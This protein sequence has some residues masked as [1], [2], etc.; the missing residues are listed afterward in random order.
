MKAQEMRE[1]F[2]KYLIERGHKEFPSASLLPD[3]DPSV[4]FTTAGMHPLVPY[5]LGERHPQGKRL[6][7]AQKCLRTDDI[8]EVGDEFHHTYFEMLGNWSLGD[9]FKNESI[10]MSF[11]FLT[12]VLSIPICKLAVTVFGG[13]EEIP[14]DTEVYECWKNVGLN[15]SQIFYGG[16]KENWWGPAGKTGPCGPDTEIF[17]DTGKEPCGDDCSPLCD[18][19]RFVEIWNNVFMQYNKDDEGHF[20]VLSQKNVDT[21]MS[22]ER[23]LAVYNHVSSNYGTDLFEPIIIRIEELTNIFRSKENI[24]SFRIIVDHLRAATFI[25]G[26]PKKVVPSNTEQGYIVR[27]LIRRS[28]RHLRKIGVINNILH[29]VINTIIEINSPVYPELKT[30]K[31]F[32]LEQI[33]KEYTSFISTLDRGIKKAEHFFNNISDGGTLTGELA[34]RLFDTFGFPIEFTVELATEKGI[35]VDIDGFNSKF[36]EH[37]EKSRSSAEGKFKGGLADNS[38]QTTKLHTATHLLNS[39]LRQV[40]GDDVYQR[41]SNITPERL[42]FDFSFDRKLTNEEL[43]KVSQ[44]VNEAISKNIPVE[45]NEMTV[46]EAKSLGAIGVFDQKYGETVKVYSIDG[47]SKEICGGPHTLNTGELGSF[48]I[49]KEESSSSGVRRIKAIINY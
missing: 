6:V 45:C 16:M 35:L 5:L 4:L 12:S 33:E 15:E 17:Y 40:L 7:N 39:A 11:E 8:D 19:G 21:G 10:T 46:D 32:I 37:Q 3:N 34:F 44:I 2:I 9:Y 22:L 49:L 43:I 1:T 25:I 42:R 47:Y 26:D 27:R 24:K 14:K 38:V 41:G 48:N 36:L 31:E 30:N 29:D 13:Y 18:C 23:I 20:I 28:I